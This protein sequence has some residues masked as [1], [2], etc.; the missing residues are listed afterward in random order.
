MDKDQLV[1]RIF[2]RSALPL[3][4][5]VGEEIPKF[6]K[7]W[8]RNAVL[9]FSVKGSDVGAALVWEDRQL[10]VHQGLH[11][12]PCLNLVFSSLDGLNGFFAGKM[13]LP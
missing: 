5:V 8:P 3:T 12:K 4:K 6:K 11:P 7:L 9:Q 13:G 1:S 10:S 2:L